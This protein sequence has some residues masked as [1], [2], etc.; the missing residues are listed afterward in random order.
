MKKK[1]KKKKK[2]THTHT[3]LIPISNGYLLRI[4]KDNE[5]YCSW[6]KEKTHR[7][8]LQT[9]A[10]EIIISCSD[11]WKLSITCLCQNASDS[12]SPQQIIERTPTL[13]SLF[14][15]SINNKR[16]NPCKHEMPNMR[17][18]RV[19]GILEWTPLCQKL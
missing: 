9:Q 11:P 13:W 19:R 17:Y 16:P 12:L 10:Y 2:K 8:L 3:I 14:L 6:F 5:C 7:I 4:R 15:N 18:F 1:K